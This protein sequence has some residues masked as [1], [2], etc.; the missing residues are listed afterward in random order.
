M[1]WINRITGSEGADHL[2]APN[3]A[4]GAFLLKGPDVRLNYVPIKNS[5]YLIP[6]EQG[7]ARV[8][9][10]EMVLE[11]NFDCPMLEQTHLGLSLSNIAEELALAETFHDFKAISPLISK[12]ED[13]LGL[14]G[15]EQLLIEEL[16]HLE[17]ITR[18]PD[19]RLD[20]IEEKQPV[21]RVSRF[22]NRSLPELSAH[23]EGWLRRKY[24]SVIPRQ[25]LSLRIDEEMDIYENRVTARLIREVITYL[26]KRIDL[27]L[28][29]LEAFFKEIEKILERHTHI[30]RPIWHRKVHRNYELIGKAWQG[31]MHEHRDK[32][33]KTH[34][35]LSTARQRLLAMLG[36]PFFSKVH[37]YTQL[38][39]NLHLTNRFQNHPHYRSVFFLWEEL[40]HLQQKETA[41]ERQNRY[42]QTLE[43]FEQYGF[44]LLIQALHLLKFKETKPQVRWQ[45]SDWSFSHPGLGDLK[46]SWDAR[47]RGF[48]LQ[49]GGKTWSILPWPDNNLPESAE[50]PAK[51]TYLLYF[52]TT[53]A[54][55]KITVG[56]PGR[57]GYIP[58]SL[59]SPDSIE[60][61][62]RAI[63]WELSEA[64]FSS[65]RFR[66]VK[67]CLCCGETFTPGHDHT[68][69]E[70]TGSC[71][72]CEIKFGL[73]SG[74]PFL[75]VNKLLKMMQHT[76]ANLG[77]I[78]EKWIDE[79]FGKDILGFP[80]LSGDKITWHTS[81]AQI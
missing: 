8:D 67:A 37:G 58:V 54:P 78:D 26:N 59:F 61:V 42:T 47:I 14:T 49:G 52:Y 6:N 66:E 64:Y 48:S 12:I 17:H 57:L 38:G 56:H 18:F 60:R 34:D 50:N 32:T 24:K 13:R 80:T 65:A 25:V 30:N 63:L 2:Q 11:Q 20:R 19:M 36:L 35:L 74:I 5:S 1:V 62:A 33:R 23:S 76:R 77:E 72:S 4:L 69:R 9:L 29:Q 40:A 28:K 27:E 7:V 75:E 22:S 15:F 71:L 81:S 51:T 70:A 46:I 3:G 10:G 68:L 16:F 31:G 21:S 39:R 79:E 43:H 41:E 73:R 44:V 55:E 45:D 53:P